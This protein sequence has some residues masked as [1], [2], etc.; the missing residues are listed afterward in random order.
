MNKKQIALILILG[1]LLFSNALL[2]A[3]YIVSTKADLI[4]KMG[5]ALPDDT[6]IVSNGSYNWGQVSFSNKTGSAT[7]SWIVLKS[8]TFNGV[9]FTGNT[10]LQFSGKHILITGFRFV[11]GNA[12]ANDVIQFRSSSGS[13]ANYCRVTNITIDNYNSDSTGSSNNTGTKN[14]GDILNRWVSLYGTHNRVDHCTF[15]NKFNGDPTVVVWYDST[16]YPA[17]GTSTYHLIDSNYFKGRG[18]QG[19]NEGEVIRVGTSVNSR[20]D[21]YNIV[22]YNLFEDGVQLD[23]EIISNKSGFNTYR[24]NTFR[25]HAGGITLRE[26]RHCSVYGNN[27][28]KTT[29]AKSTQYGIRIIDK[30]HKIFNNYLENLDGNYNSNTSLRCPIVLFNGITNSNDTTDPAFAAKYFAAD[31]AIVAFNTIVNCYGGAGIVLGFEVDNLG[32]YKPKGVIVANNLVSMKKGQAVY[33]DTVGS[34]NPVTYF[35]EGNIYSA[36]LNLGIPNANGFNNNTLSFKTRANGILS[37]PSLVQDAAVNTNNYVSL[38]NGLDVE[39]KIRGA[40]YDVGA[41]EINGM[42]NVVAIPLDSTMVGAGTPIVPLPVKLLTF[43]GEIKDGSAVL[44]WNV[45][46][47]FGLLQY[48]VEASLNGNEFNKIGVVAATNTDTYRFVASL[49]A[50]K[51][52]YRL[53][54]VNKDGSYL[55]SKVILIASNE[56]RL[57]AIYPNPAKDFVTVFSKN[58]S[59]NITLLIKNVLGRTVLEKTLTNNSSATIT[60]STNRLSNG[61]YFLQVIEE[62]KIGKAYPFIISR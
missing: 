33:I 6:I 29:T 17:K 15:I 10:Y 8:E 56:N 44:N 5:A 58:I 60:I 1:T 53:K 11:N 27:F 22:E 49:T 34:I 41:L 38:L 36:P 13:F 54:M 28:I 3:N 59:P 23:P 25:N 42:G 45:V 14:G 2:A 12:G 62:G 39:A 50:S 19:G 51:N 48:E 30:G 4:S 9:A 61:S 31:S 32:L 40:I 21:G 57:V 37:P 26:G 18:Y 20:T 47:E 16:N 46:D 52:Y 55:Y 43:M 35:A 24:Y 7:S